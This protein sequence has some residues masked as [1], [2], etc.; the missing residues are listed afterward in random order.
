MLNILNSIAAIILLI[1]GLISMINPVP[2]GVILIAIGMSML[3]CSN[4]KVQAYIKFLRAKSH[5]VNKI[6]FWM[7]EKVGK[8][9]NFIG[10]ALAK[11]QLQ[12]EA[13]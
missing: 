4:A 8:K 10:I 7:E 1:I 3:I 2:G 11:T 6:F 9:I 5:K 12:I 13:R